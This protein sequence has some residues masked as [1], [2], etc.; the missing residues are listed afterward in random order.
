[1]RWVK[2]ALAHGDEQNID[3]TPAEIPFGAVDTQPQLAGGWQQADK[4]L[5]QHEIVQG[6]ES[7]KILNPGLIRGRFG[8]VVEVLGHLAK[9][10]VAALYQANN[11]LGDEL[12]PREVAHQGH[13][14]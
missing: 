1:M 9:L 13:V 12:L 5:C 10:H 4:E 14:L 8:R 7:E 2:R 11:E 3:L 6:H